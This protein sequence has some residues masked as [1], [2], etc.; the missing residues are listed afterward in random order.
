M[1]EAVVTLLQEEKINF[2]LPKWEPHDLMIRVELSEIVQNVDI[3]SRVMN[4][5]DLT[6]FQE[7]NDF[8]NYLFIKKIV[9]LRSIADLIVEN[10]EAKEK[11]ESVC[12]IATEHLQ[13]RNKQALLSFLNAHYREIFSISCTPKLLIWPEREI[14]EEVLAFQNGGISKD[15]Y[16]FLLEE[17]PSFLR[18]N[19]K[20]LWKKFEENPEWFEKLCA[21]EEKTTC[22]DL[23]T[24]ITNYSPIFVPIWRRKSSNLK[25]CIE[26]N[27][28]D[29]I[30]RVRKFVTDVTSGLNDEVIVAMVLV[31]KGAMLLKD[32]AWEFPIVEADQLQVL[33]ERYNA[34]SNPFW[35]TYS[36][37]IREDDL[38]K[39]ATEI[40]R[41]PDKHMRVL[42]ITHR[43]H[44]ST[45]NNW[46]DLHSFLD[47]DYL[48]Q[49][50][51][52]LH[53]FSCI[54][55]TNEYFTITRQLCLRVHSEHI[56]IFAHI[57]L[58]EAS[59][60][61]DVMETQKE[62]MAFLHQKLGI[63]EGLIV[64]SC[65]LEGMI[66]AINFGDDYRT[67]IQPS[68]YG[69]SM[70]LCALIEKLLRDVWKALDGGKHEVP[71]G[72]AALRT[73]LEDSSGVFRNIFGENHLRNL[74]YFLCHVG[75]DN[76]IGLGFRNRLAHWDGIG[77]QN[78]T[79]GFV[80]FL[81]YLYQDI[82]NT[83]VIHFYKQENSCTERPSECQ[84]TNNSSV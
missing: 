61:N 8:L 23:I 14:M 78:L 13:R 32:L 38:S 28:K 84:D 33:Y 79:S 3:F 29:V 58:R 55:P 36:F 62:M 24:F 70:F 71:Q 45:S 80:A 2:S 57:I 47:T 21:T 27:V 35:K 82:L 25:C 39:E 64:D 30:N 37:T 69:A 18:G 31:T 50:H 9:Y 51:D 26:E 40:A 52:I 68:C 83:L 43:Y 6:H 34:P 81:Y 11:I 7:I 65:I 48:P 54:N 66:R 5:V 72:A 59:W 73:L 76:S 19:F 16:V 74:S 41:H 75:Q 63:T 56:R 15:V 10:K 17:H 4:Q 22:G 67:M 1:T 42:L 20:G 53:T 60:L 12:N 44:S 46:L 49:A 77:A